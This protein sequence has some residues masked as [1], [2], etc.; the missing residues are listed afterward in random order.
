MGLLSGIGKAIKGIVGTVTGGDLL[1]AGASLLGGERANQASAASTAEQM[2]FQERMSN[3]AHQREVKD[4]KEAG[5]NTMLSALGSGA[6]TPQGA[7]TVFNDTITPALSSARQAA[8][9]RAEIENMKASNEQIHSNVDLNKAL[10]TK[11][12]ADAYLSNATAANVK[13]QRPLIEAQ[14]AGAENESNFNKSVGDLAPWAR[15]SLQF[16]REL[17][18]AGSSAKSIMSK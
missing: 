3:T 7:S 16:L 15:N 11:A 13:A 14:Q 2:A 1:S 12:R 5:L 8:R 17:L 4:L 9:V 18:G 6:S 10:M